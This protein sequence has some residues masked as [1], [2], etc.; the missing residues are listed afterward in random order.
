M[1]KNLEIY[2]KDPCFPKSEVLIIPSNTAGLLTEGIQ[3]RILKT[4]GKKI[5]KLASK[6]VN[7]NKVDLGDCF[8]TDSGRLK[9]R[10]CKRLYHCVIKR[11]P[12]DFTSLHMLEQAIPNALKSVINDGWETVTICG[13]G[14]E[15]GDL[16]PISVSRIFL[17]NCEKYINKINIKIIDE[18][19][20]F[21]DSLND[22]I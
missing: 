10:K 6:Y 7:E 1:K 13:I 22:M 20:S 8:S 15:P 11:L 14:I 21:I 2:C 5:Q 4:A 17:L 3:N 18:N 12:G 9:R 16:D 19:E